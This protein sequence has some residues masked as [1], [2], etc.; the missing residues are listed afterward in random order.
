[1][2]KT[3]DLKLEMERAKKHP[4]AFL[5]MQNEEKTLEKSVKATGK[6]LITEKK[7]LPSKKTIK[8]KETNKRGRSSSITLKEII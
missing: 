8:G 6:S 5:K 2:G 1:M 3:P 4:K 7:V